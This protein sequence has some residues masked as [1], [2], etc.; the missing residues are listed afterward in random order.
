MLHAGY[1]TAETANMVNWLPGRV[2]IIRL[3]RLCEVLMHGHNGV[4]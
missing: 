3:I 4:F 2:A 1:S